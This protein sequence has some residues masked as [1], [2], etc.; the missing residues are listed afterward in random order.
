MSRPGKLYL[1]SS[2]CKT[3]KNEE[4][5]YIL[6]LPKKK[7]HYLYIYICPYSN[8]C[9]IWKVNA[10][11][12]MLFEINISW[13]WVFRFLTTNQFIQYLNQL[14]ISKVFTLWLFN[15]FK[16]MGN[17]R[18]YYFIMQF[19][20]TDIGFSFLFILSLKKW[21]LFYIIKEL[22]CSLKLVSAIIHQFFIFNQ[23]TDLQK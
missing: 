2:F 5:I 7:I 21:T 18:I 20:N 3:Q 1:W 19:N 14:F 22:Q 16:H 9:I 10:S 12:N 13:K 8:I 23:M 17:N 15:I 6:N 11:K 4:W